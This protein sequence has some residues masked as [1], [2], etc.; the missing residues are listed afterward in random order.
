MSSFF[1]TIFGVLGYLTLPRGSPIRHKLIFVIF[2]M[3]GLGSVLFHGSLLH[4]TQ[5][6][7][8]CVSHPMTKEKEATG[9]SAEIQ[10]MFSRK[11]QSIIIL[12]TLFHWFFFLV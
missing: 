9:L 11:S 12:I 4:K 7:G 2:A 10:V 8:K 3:V 1:I 6:L 5:M